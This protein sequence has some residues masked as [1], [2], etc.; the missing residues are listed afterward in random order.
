[1]D[2][3]LRPLLALVLALAPAATAVAD[4]VAL[5]RAEGM[6]LD[7][8][9]DEPGWGTAP[10][11]EVLPFRAPPRTGPTVPVDVTPVVRL[12][13]ADGSLWIG[14]ETPQDPGIAS[15]VKGMIAPAGAAEGAASAADAFAFAYMPV[16]VRSP[17]Y[18][19]RGPRGVGR[20]T[21]RLR[22]AADLRDPAAT[23]IEVAIPLA[24]LAPAAADVPLRIAL[25]V[26]GRSSD[27]I[28]WAPPGAGFSDP[29]DWAVLRPPEGGWPKEPAAVDAEA[30]AREDA[31]DAERTAAWNRALEGK[32]KPV[33]AGSPEQVWETI[34]K[35]VVEPLDAALAAR[36]DLGFL[37]VVKADVYRQMGRYA[38]A[39]AAARAALGTLPTLREALFTLHQSTA[40]TLAEGAPGRPTDYAAALAK[41]D[42]AAAAAKEPYE[43]EGVDVA[44]GMLLHRR[45]DH[46][47]AAALL[48]PLAERYPFSPI[49]VEHAE[50]AAKYAAAWPAEQALRER[51]AK[52]DDL[53]RARIV[54]PRGDVVVELFEDEAP[55]TVKNFVWLAEEGFYAGTKFHRVVP[56]FVAQ[57]GDPMSRSEETK[58]EVGAGGPC[59][60]IAT[61]AGPRKA[62]RGVLAMARSAKKDTEGS[63]FFLTTGAA[64][65]LDGEYTVFGRI[66]EGQEVAERLEQGD[67]IERVQVLRKRPGTTY[68]PATTAGTPAPKP[69]DC[70]PR[71][72]R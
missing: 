22:G 34:R 18:V 31:K 30:I 35:N 58:A 29:A 5:S 49:L 1:M 46:A 62:F 41:V 66:L 38:D 3:R 63:Q 40:A 65:H 23:R 42:E 45:G 44:R 16:D 19:A 17:T 25:A 8:R 61:E 54:T 32:S 26:G 6:T 11:I 60:A 24:D 52:K 50:R 36:P 59:Y 43:K 9:L 13:V 27:Q 2:R 56:Y 67:A 48:K 55:N 12:L 57:G 64:N 4:D 53:P 20:A 69:G 68:R 72:R 33:P 51:D 7:G 10:R 39:A 71:G 47:Q 21:Y 14:V 28:G 15:G 70:G 37:H